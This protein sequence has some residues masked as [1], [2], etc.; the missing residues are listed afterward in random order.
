MKGE[1]WESAR[2][3]ENQPMSAKIVNTTDGIQTLK[4]AGKLT[5]PELSAAQKQAAE[6]LEQQGKISILVLTEDFRAGSAAA[7]GA[8]SRSRR[9]MTRSSRSSR[10]L[11]RSNGRIWRCSLPR[12]DSENIPW[13]Y[14]PPTELSQ[15]RAWLAAK[16]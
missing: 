12:K 7:L 15:A 10:S 11:A 1:F 14:F 13:K 4:I 5:Q 8:T 9:R 3:I 2:P 6:I 16:P